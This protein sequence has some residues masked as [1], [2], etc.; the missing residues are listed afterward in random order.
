MWRLRAWKPHR[1]RSTGMTTSAAPAKQ[2]QQPTWTELNWS[3]V[4]FVAL[5][6]FAS[7]YV[8]ETALTKGP[9]MLPT[10]AVSGEV[11]L[12]DKTFNLLPWRA[13]SKGDIVVAKS[14]LD[15]G[16]FICKVSA[17]HVARVHGA[18]A[19]HDA[20]QRVT[21]VAGDAIGKGSRRVP[22]GRLWLEGD[23]KANS[24]DSREYGPVPEALVVGKVVARIWPP[25]RFGPVP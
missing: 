11:F 25:G 21:A 17:S 5:F 16:G 8:C 24:L 10:V 12:V 1:R 2:Q 14:P 19:L 20:R 3:L 23:N 15:P 9:S 22:S 18:D 13:Y 6:L 4:K 7:E